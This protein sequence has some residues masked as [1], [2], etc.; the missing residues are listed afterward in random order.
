M[1]RILSD[2]S[3]LYS[4]EQ[5]EQAGFNVA[6]LSVTIAGKTYREFDEISSKEFV[7]IIHQGHMPTSSQPAIGEV[8][9]LYE[10]YPDDELLNI[11]MAKGL[12]STYD[13]AVAAKELCDHSD[14]ITVI[15]SR[16]L[17]GPHRY[18]VEKATQMAAEGA[19]LKEITDRVEELMLTA[20]SYLIPS[21]FSY[22]R[23]GGRLSPLVS[24][25]GQA[26]QL[27]PILTQTEDGC[28][29]TMAAVRRGFK[30]AVTHVGKLLSERCTGS[31]WRI[32]ITHA[33]AQQS[34]EQALTL[35]K[36]LIPSA[37]FEIHPLSPVFITQGGPSCVAI[38]VIHE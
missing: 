25:V 38:Q 23:R 15:N 35:L 2:T 3:T 22:L 6:P 29:L 19:S 30:Q 9:A 14:H 28:Q 24:Y 27:A 5:A 12:S 20:K 13:S 32:Y 34:A 17:C 31:G 36:A 16:T 11:S 4:T 37:T 1:V 8:A 10:Q 21:D 26:V 33:D 7:S 18:I